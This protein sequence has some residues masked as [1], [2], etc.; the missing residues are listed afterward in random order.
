MH[1]ILSRIGKLRANPMPSNDRHIVCHFHSIRRSWPS[2]FEYVRC[3]TVKLVG[4]III[5]FNRVSSTNYHPFPASLFSPFQKWVSFYVRFWCFRVFFISQNEARAGRKEFVRSFRLTQ[6][7]L[8]R[9]PF[10]LHSSSCESVALPSYTIQIIASFADDVLVHD[11]NPFILFY[12]RHTQSYCRWRR[13]Y[14][15][16]Y[17]RMFFLFVFSPI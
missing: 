15:H 8:P 11:V 4:Y 10:I 3:S 5:G 12:V 7:R 1:S 6:Q 14:I 13:I 2:H 17:V 9:N 16:I